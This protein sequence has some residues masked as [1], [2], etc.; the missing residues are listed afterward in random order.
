MV[1]LS[2]NIKYFTPNYTVVSID[3]D[4]FIQEKKTTTEF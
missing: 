2:E 1:T 4:K 3:K